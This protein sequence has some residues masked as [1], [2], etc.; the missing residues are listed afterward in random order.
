VREKDN[1]RKLEVK[2]IG[3]SEARD[4]EGLMYDKIPDNY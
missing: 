3:V 4:L 2:T 1:E